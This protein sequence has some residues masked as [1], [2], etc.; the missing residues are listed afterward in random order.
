MARANRLDRRPYLL[1]PIDVANGRWVVDEQNGIV[2]G[3]RQIGPAFLSLFAVQGQ[4][5]SIGYTEVAGTLHFT[6]LSGDQNGTMTGGEDTD[7]KTSLDA[8][9]PVEWFEVGV[10]QEAILR[11]NSPADNSGSEPADP[12]KP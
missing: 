1:K 6:V 4:L 12:E 8:I 9:P 5:L 11:R 7:Q 3:S 2:L 10:W